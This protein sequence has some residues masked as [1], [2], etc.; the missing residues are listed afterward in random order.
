MMDGFS[1]MTWCFP[2]W[3]VSEVSH[4]FPSEGLSAGE[5]HFSS[6]FITQIWSLVCTLWCEVA[7]TV[8]F[9]WSSS[10]KRTLLA[11]RWPPWLWRTQ[12]FG[13]S[14]MQK[15]PLIHPFLATT[16]DI[17]PHNLHLKLQQCSYQS[18]EEA[19]QEFI[20]RLTNLTHVFEVAPV[21]KIM[22]GVQL[23]IHTPAIRLSRTAE[24]SV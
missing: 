1:M 9:G 7:C 4:T 13:L 8:C 19:W 6:L 17:I 22:P 11:S 20:V 3:L 21:W 24:L 14:L 16:S 2:Q 5:R 18:P 23:N 15:G 10:L 12:C